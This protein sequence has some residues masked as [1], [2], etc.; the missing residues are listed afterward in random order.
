MPCESGKSHWQLLMQ[1][2]CDR[3]LIGF[4]Y[5]CRNVDDAIISDWYSVLFVGYVSK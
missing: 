5:E 1:G 4:E 3:I 2:V